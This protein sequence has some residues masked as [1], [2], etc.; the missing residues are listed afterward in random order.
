[1]RVPVVMVHGLWSAPFT[2]LEMFNELRALPEIRNRYQ[3]WF[4]LYPTGQPF[5][6]SAKQMRK[7]LAEVRH[8]IDPERHIATM[9]QM[10]LI[11]HSMG[12]LVS[13]L[14]TIDSGDAFWRLVSDDPF[15]QIETDVETKKTIRDTL[16]FRA[17]PA[18]KRVVT[19]GTPHRGS[20]FANNF[21]RWLG[22][23]FIRLPDLL[24]SSVL[25][26]VRNRDQIFKNKE[27]LATKTSIDSLSPGS[28]FLAQLLNS[29]SAP[30]V[31]T[32]NIVGN[33]E[34][35]KYLGVAG[36]LMPTHSDGIV[37][38]ASSQLE[39]AGSYVQVD[40]KHQYI[41]MQPK[42]ILEVR[43][44]LM[45]HARQVQQ[46]LAARSRFSKS[47]PAHYQAPALP[48]LDSRA[49]PRISSIP[50]PQVNR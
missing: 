41:H 47:Q 17:N 48:A 38:T 9:D 33:I 37:S 35:R 23:T 11:G 6:M 7:D 22:H 39:A 44:I 12:G 4:Y 5:W 10:V 18:V 8:N 36:D 24:S 15:D 43:R 45:E 50:V 30:W 21:T 25:K 26:K 1:K 19:I 42:A 3:F 28:P 20:E 32:H 2:W 31:T 46:E 40:A 34:R 14:Q 16:F 29:Q 49:E 13:R 27:I